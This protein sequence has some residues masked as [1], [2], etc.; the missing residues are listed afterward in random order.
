[1]PLCTLVFLRR[2]TKTGEEILLAMKKRGF[3]NG[4]WNG[5]GGKV[6]P[7]E[8]VEQAMIRECQEEISVTPTTYERV[9]YHD[10]V[11]DAATTPWQQQVHAYIC[12]EWTGEPTESEEMKPQWF[13]LGEIPYAQ[14]W[15]DDQLWVPLVLKGKKVQGT[16]TFD[17]HDD[18]LTAQINIFSEL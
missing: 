6:D 10:F 2:E 14:M 5:A 4:L 3:G 1:M 13:A 18:M 11:N 17:E 15:Q 12:T 7:G 9:A 16:F 8:T